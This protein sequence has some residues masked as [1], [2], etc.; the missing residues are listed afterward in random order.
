MVDLIDEI[1]QP[2]TEMLSDFIT[3][4]ETIMYNTKDP[5][6]DTVG[7][8]ETDIVKRK[9]IKMNQI[10]PSPKLGSVGFKK[11][12]YASKIENSKFKEHTYDSQS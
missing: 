9:N 3:H 11:A 4:K 12:S 7:S 5:N 2:V 6:L 8:M 10:S 1:E